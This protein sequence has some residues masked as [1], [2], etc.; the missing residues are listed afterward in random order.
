[1][2]LPQVDRFL[3]LGLFIF[4]R[5]S[6]EG[7]RDRRKSRKVDLFH[8]RDRRESGKWFPSERLRVVFPN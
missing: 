8:L 6:R 7:E 5:R 2:D 3:I 1:M 4:E